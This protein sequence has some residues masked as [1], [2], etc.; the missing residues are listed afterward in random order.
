VL[1]ALSFGVLGLRLGQAADQTYTG[2]VGSVVGQRLI[3]AHYPG[4]TSSPAQIIT[5]ANTATQVV[6]AAAAVDGVAGARPAG[7][8]ANGRWVRVEAVLADP[9]DS[10]A[11]KATV[12]RLRGAVHA[13]PGSAALVGGETAT[14]LDIERAAERDNWVV[15]PLILL[16]VFVVLVLLLRSILAPLLLV[17]SVVLSYAAAMGVGGLV[18]QAL[19]YAG[20]MPSLPLYCFL[21][22]VTLG[23]D[24]TIFLMTRAREEVAKVG[25]RKGILS[26]LA[27]TGGVITS[28][29]L[30][31]AGTFATLILL[32]VVTALQI[33]LIV[34][35]GVLLD[36]FVVRTLLI[37]A[38]AVDVGSRIWWPGRSVRQPVQVSDAVPQYST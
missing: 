23:V 18:S 35:V 31:L 27:V 21:L 37:P 22:L 26:A 15:L 11:A 29:G 6:A 33:G 20:I 30:V 36:T 38:L 12:D 10:A 9:P 13:V 5:T 3:D 25:N 4:G 19:G 1:V 16:V 34:A 7:V 17:G 28:A 14:T 24:Y 2:D 32:P 8:S